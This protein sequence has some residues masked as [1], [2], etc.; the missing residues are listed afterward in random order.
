MQIGL[1]K[2]DAGDPETAPGSCA[3][4]QRGPGHIGSYNDAIS[5][6]EVQRHLAGA[7]SDFGDPRVAGNGPI[8]ELSEPAASGACA[9]RRKAVAGRVSRKRRGLVE[10]AHGLGPGGAVQS[11][12]RNAIGRVEARTA[13]EASPLG[14]QRGAA[15]RTGQQLEEVG[16]VVR[17]SRR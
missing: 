5:T 8:Q 17:R 15:R 9:E 14:R 10:R 4:E 16:H 13:A 6:R 11:E 3:K 7:A 2:M 1:D 12:I